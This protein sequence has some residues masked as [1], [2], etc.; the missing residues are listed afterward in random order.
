MND[1]LFKEYAKVRQALEDFEKRKDELEL[2]IMDEL[3]HDNVPGRETP[4]GVFTLSSR[5]SWEYSQAVT[6]ATANLRALKT[7]EVLTDIARLRKDTR[8]LSFSKAKGG[9]N[10]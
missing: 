2:L 5:R 7:Q 4:Y 6:V 10:K 1:K 8:I 9:E 3:D